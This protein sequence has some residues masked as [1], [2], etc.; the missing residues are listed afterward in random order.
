M[1]KR[2]SQEDIN[3]QTTR[4]P[5]N[6]FELDTTGYPTGKDG[7]V[8]ATYDLRQAEI[9]RNALLTQHI[10]CKLKEIRLAGK[11]L[12][13][14]HVAGEKELEEAMGFIWRD[15]SGLRLKPDWSYADGE[16]NKSF[17]L[18]LSGH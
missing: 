8:W 5:E 4:S 2:K 3:H 13:F 7:T 6:K 1:K 16:V 11:A 18:W 14:L 12:H 9:I 15:A 17:E 10:G